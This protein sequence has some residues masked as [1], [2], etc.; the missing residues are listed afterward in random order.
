[1][2]HNPY[3]G[4]RPYE[5]DDR[6]NFFG[7]DRDARDLVALI[8]AEREVLFY[9][10][11]GA[12]KTSLLNAQVIPALEEEG[13]QVLPV[14]RVGSSLPPGISDQAVSNI[15]VFSALMG[16]AGANIPVEALPKHTLLSFLCE[17]CL[18]PSDGVKRRPP[19]LILD[20]FEELFT[21]HQDRWKDAEGFFQQV[22]EA[23][24]AEPCLGIVLAMREDHV[25]E[26]DPYV[27]IL[28]HRLLGRYRMERLRY[29]EALEA[30]TQPALNES[31]PFEPGVA[32]RLVE[33][34]C[35]IKVLGLEGAD[36]KVV[37]GRYVEAVQLQVVCQ[38]LWEN[39][40]DAPEGDRA[41]QWEEVERYGN[42][43]RALTNFYESVL[44]QTVRETGV[45][46]R[47]LRRWFSTQLI[48]P[49]QTRGLVL[50]EEKSTA[51]LPNEAVAVLDKQ[52]LIRADMRAGA[53]WYELVH[54][55]LV[56]PIRANNA[57]WFQANLSALQRQADLWNVQG[58]QAGLLLREKAL[59]D[60]EEWA[61]AHEADLNQTERDF[62]Q[63]CRAGRAAAERER[64]QNRRIR[65]LAIGTTILS[66][67]A[68]G[69]LALALWFYFSA[70]E[71]QKLAH[72]RELAARATLQ[73]KADPEQS[74]LLAL[75][76]V[77]S[78]DTSEAENALRQAPVE[79][80]LRVVLRGHTSW[81]S[82]AVFSPDGRAILT[83]SGDG[84]ARIWDSLT[85]ESLVELRGH[86]KQINTASFSP[87]SRFVLT[88]SDDG[89]ARVWDLQTCNPDCRFVE[90]K[91]HTQSVSFAV[92]SPDGTRIATASDDMTARIWDAA[93]GRTLFVLEG[94]TQKVNYVV[95]SPDGKWL[96]TSSEDS[97]ARIWDAGTG[98]SLRDLRGHNGPIMKVV[99]SMNGQ[100]VATASKDTTARVW[101]VTT[102]KLLAELRGH[103][104][105]LTDIA[106]SSDSRYVVT[107]SSDQTARVWD[108]QTCNPNCQ[109]TE[110]RGHTSAVNS[111]VFSQDGRLVLTASADQTA[112]LWET[113]SGHALAELRGHT[114]WVYAAAFNPEGD[115]I[116]TAS[117]DG[118][119]RVW[120]ANPA[121]SVIELQGHTLD[122]TS[123]AFSQDGKYI[124]TASSDSNARVWEAATGRTRIIL[125]GHSDRLNR[126]TFSPDGRFVATASEDNTARVWDLDNCN[127][128]CSFIELKGHKLGVKSVRFSP[129][130]KY[131]VT[132]SNDQ[133]ARI[134]DWRTCKDPAEC[135]FTEL[136]GHTDWVLDA[137]FSPDGKFIVTAS[138][139]ADPTAAIWDSGT[140]NLLYKLRGH[141]TAL[142]NAVFSPDGRWIVT[143]SRD[144]T[145]RVWDWRTCKNETDCKFTE[146]KG[147]SDWVL[148][149]AFSPDG[150]WVVTSSRDRTAR[151]WDWN[152]GKLI[153]ELRGHTGDVTSSAFSP[154]SQFLVTASGDSTARI[155]PR[156][157]FAPFKEVWGT[158]CRQIAHALTPAERELCP[159][160]LVKGGQP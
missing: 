33:N 130:G 148:D 7:R 55:R 154:D 17:F 76:A 136:K 30:V 139:E 142:T 11:S 122:V 106:F 5:R 127:P 124:V 160:D 25:A 85:G 4:P 12:G 140:G 26:L 23:L 82:R 152:S 44:A 146:L 150:Q 80:R 54:D 112:R 64:K 73:L 143:A 14:T 53:W 105:K 86:A 75:Q 69:A 10:Q 103:T 118:T 57:A 108:L 92:F 6:H 84:T 93:T 125:S 153:A 51:G 119:A 159:S 100:Y 67:I 123:A 81:V 155:W 68:L 156:T 94:H 101:E 115:R 43:D 1:M 89:T 50:K 39:L 134:W 65:S 111:A 141:K 41:I 60:A 31:C 48:T 22:R 128:D 88:A 77:Q 117:A 15:F 29:E 71:Q 34:L 104:D 99:F 46:E 120:E 66:V 133:T 145:A 9:A 37:A 70:V 32:E 87:D 113:F 61:Q 45:K 121:M 42:I 62:L 2:K 107:A 78:A 95:Y 52:L 126:A 147:H 59:V 132:A 114:Y 63:D 21:T 131:V 72:S 16:L 18:K 36:Q 158:A 144:N 56:E 83:A 19:L 97:T 102:G 47:D 137:A 20:Q 49:M 24:D 96:A 91:G 27:Q 109:F 151:V 28:S 35:Q 110:L 138:S 135:K 149:A 98:Q 116:V 40:P 13:F 58:R 38:Q 157:F 8:L 79:N 3:V 129:D 74:V 90:L